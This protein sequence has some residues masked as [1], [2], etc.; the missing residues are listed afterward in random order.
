M[1]YEAVIPKTKDQVES[2]ITGDDPEELCHAVLSAALHSKDPLWAESI[3]L[4]LAQHPHEN[5][6]G[7]AILGLGHIARIHRHLNSNKIK[8]LIETAL[9]DESDYVRGQAKSAADDAELF[10]KWSVAR[11]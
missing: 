2:A 10:L 6:R 11:P 8:P 7:N 9:K 5:I 1:K 4:Q 3:C